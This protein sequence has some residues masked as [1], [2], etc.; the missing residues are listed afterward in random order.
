MADWW[1]PRFLL[2][3]DFVPYYRPQN[4]VAV[5]FMKASPSN[6]VTG[7]WFENGLADAV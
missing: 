6:R 2:E 3:V 1:N 4:A 7:V 5:E